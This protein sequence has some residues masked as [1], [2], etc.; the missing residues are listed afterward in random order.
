MLLFL[1]TVILEFKNL[2][3]AILL[4]GVRQLYCLFITVSLL[5]FRQPGSLFAQQEFPASW[6]KLSLVVAVFLCSSSCAL[7]PCD[8]AEKSILPSS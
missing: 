6:L 2:S 5:A 3:F 4:A 1:K 7:Q 8:L